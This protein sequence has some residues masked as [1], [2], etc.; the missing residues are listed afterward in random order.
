MCFFKSADSRELMR[1]VEKNHIKHIRHKVQ[2]EGYDINGTVKTTHFTDSHD[3]INYAKE[4]PL[5][6][7]CVLGNKEI[8]KELIKLGA[9]VNKPMMNH[10]CSNPNGPHHTQFYTPFELAYDNDHS[11][12]AQLLVDSK[13]FVIPTGA[14][15]LYLIHEAKSCEMLDVLLGMTKNRADI[16]AAKR[17][18][19]ESKKPLFKEYL[20]KNKSSS[21]SS[22]SSSSSESEDESSFRVKR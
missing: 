11:A 9:D 13:K 20:N 18:I 14:D 3:R 4:T 16:V 7:A 5:T 8:V 2:V 19:R 17:H 1:C 10:D 22:A 21:S 6:R 15:Y 12:C